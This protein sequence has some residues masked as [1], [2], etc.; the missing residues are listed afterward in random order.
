MVVVVVV[1]RMVIWQLSPVVVMTEPETVVV[2]FHDDVGVQDVGT[3]V[4]T[5]SVVVLVEAKRET[6][7]ELVVTVTVVVPG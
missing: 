3:V 6:V 4:V 2:P 7:G 1:G 5:K